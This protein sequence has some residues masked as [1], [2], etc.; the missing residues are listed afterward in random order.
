MA[1]KFLAGSIWS[2]L[3]AAVSILTPLLVF[4]GFARMLAPWQIG[5]MVYA[6]AVGEMVKVFTPMGLYEALLGGEDDG[7]TGAAAAGLLALCAGGALIAYV[8]VLLLTPLWMPEA[9]SLAPYTLVVGVRVVF[10]LLVLHPQS[11]I[12]RRRD[13]KRFA[14]RTL[15]ANVLAALTALGVTLALSPLA[16]M[17]AYYLAQSLVLW[18]ATVLGARP[19]PAPSFGFGRLRP[20][21]RTAFLASQVRSFGTLNNFADQILASL[22][23]SAGAVARY[24]LGKR[25]E[26][27]QVTGVQSFSSI[28]FQPLFARRGADADVGPDYRRSLFVITLLCGAPTA[29]F[30]VNA[31]AIVP[32]VFGAKWAAAAP[33]AAALAFSGLFR[34]LG[35]VQA[36]FFSVTGQN[37]ALRN[38]LLVSSI[39]GVG[40]VLCVGWLGITAVAWLLALK[41]LLVV[42][43]SAVLTRRLAGPGFYARFMAGPV[44][45]TAGA[46][47]LVTAGASRLAPRLSTLET[48]GVWIACA[49]A[50]GAALAL[51]YHREVR[52]AVQGFRRGRRGV[53]VVAPTGPASL[54]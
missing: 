3:N 30:A 51:L 37:A 18:A 27:A 8:A 47:A 13:Y 45:A 10:D 35:G 9:R 17:A 23:I 32:L 40:V 50:G 12:A 29:L 42:A 43:W 46:A 52:R 19:S 14:L 44:A 36:A 21:A 25:V 16:G 20:L 15:A 1:G 4:V 5:V 11:L 22:F 6:Y 34:A 28:L 2:G 49:C 33:V 41:N 39:A 38:R 24:N 53:A 31:G 7:P 54:G 48:L 26:M